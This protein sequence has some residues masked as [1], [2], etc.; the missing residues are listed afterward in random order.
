MVI[1]LGSLVTDTNHSNV[2]LN[3]AQELRMISCV[4]SHQPNNDF[5]GKLK[6]W[7]ERLSWD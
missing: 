6:Q 1:T 3:H 4:I 7:I 2:N 5:P